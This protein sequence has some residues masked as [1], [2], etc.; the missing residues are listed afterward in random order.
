MVD[1]DKQVA[2]WREGAS[3]DWQVAQELVG[4]GRARHGLFFAHLA[5]EKV[6]KAHVCLKTQDLAPKIHNLI[7]LAEIAGISLNDEQK[8]TLA[9][10]NAF[11]LEG[12][13]PDMLM[14]NPSREEAKEFLRRAKEVYQ[15][16]TSPL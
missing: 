3:E 11:N 6:L 5:L 8:D 12:R 1:I 15:W 10:M 4:G 9:D 7:K 2:Y 14:P 13:Y 16:L